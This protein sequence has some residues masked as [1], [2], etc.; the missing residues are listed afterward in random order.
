MG[1]VGGFRVGEAAAVS[2]PLYFHREFSCMASFY[3]RGCTA[4]Q[5]NMCSL[6]PGSSPPLC[7]LQLLLLLLLLLSMLLLLVLCC[8]C[9]RYEGALSVTIIATGFARD[10]EEELFGSGNQK[11]SARRAMPQP[12]A[13][14][15]RSS[16]DFDQQPAAAATASRG[17]ENQPWNKQDK[18]KQFFGRGIF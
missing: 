6:P 3:L 11:K 13:T 10:Y 5:V 1:R 14:T 12:A 18:P 15:T 7:L 17:S 9:G 8:F 4:C 16:N 2:L